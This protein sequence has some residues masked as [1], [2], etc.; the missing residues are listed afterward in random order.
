MEFPAL[1]EVG[2]RIQQEAGLLAPQ[3]EEEEVEEEIQAPQVPL[4]WV[5]VGLRQQ[6]PLEVEFLALQVEA[7][8]QAP[9][10]LPVWVEMEV[11]VEV[12]AKLQ[13]PH[14]LPVWVEVELRQ[15]AR[16]EVE[17]LALQVEARLQAPQR[18]EEGS[19][20]L[21][22][23]EVRVLQEEDPLVVVWMGLH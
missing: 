3:Q 18:E 12:E 21:Q 10:V 5:E 2:Q 8:L 14:V 13:T 4:V 7:R 20:T 17:I 9:Q 23:E 11:E 1:H 19:E 16:L 6:A 22:E 15:Q